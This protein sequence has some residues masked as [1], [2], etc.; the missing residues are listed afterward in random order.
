MASKRVRKEW[1]ISSRMAWPKPGGERWGKA[2]TPTSEPLPRFPRHPKSRVLIHKHLLDFSRTEE[3][4][5]PL[6]AAQTQP[7]DLQ[8][9]P[10]DGRTQLPGVEGG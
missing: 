3:N 1:F 4:C 5:A 8:G 6:S 10:P 9:L 7:E 2:V